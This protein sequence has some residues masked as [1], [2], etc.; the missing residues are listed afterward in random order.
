MGKT[1]VLNLGGTQWELAIEDCCQG[2]DVT[3][4]SP[5]FDVNISKGNRVAVVCQGDQVLSIYITA[6]FEP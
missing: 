5:A 6:Y 1:I 4:K 3:G 2:V